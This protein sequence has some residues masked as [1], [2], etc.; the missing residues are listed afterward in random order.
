MSR[1]T[2]TRYA[3][4]AAAAVADVPVSGRRPVKSGTILFNKRAQLATVSR[5]ERFQC[6]CLEFSPAQS[7]FRYTAECCALC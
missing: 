4:A 5:N 3:E 2:H 6:S 1:A 7:D